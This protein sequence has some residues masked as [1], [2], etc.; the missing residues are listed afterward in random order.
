MQVCQDCQREE[1]KTFEKVSMYVRERPGV[2]LNTIA[3]ELELSFDILMKYVREGRLQ[4]RGSDGKSVNFCE[5]CGNELTPEDMFA[6]GRFCKGCEGGMTAKLESA[7]KEMAEKL[8]GSVNQRA[9][10]KNAKSIK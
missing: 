8:A 10:L 3:T 7:R 9:F 4:V 5:K 1:E 2:P 6:G